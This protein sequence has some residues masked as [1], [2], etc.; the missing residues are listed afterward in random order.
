MR[1]SLIPRRFAFAISMV[2]G[3]VGLVFAWP[4]LVIYGFSTMVDP[5]LEHHNR[6]QAIMDRFLF[7]DGPWQILLITV[8]ILISAFGQLSCLVH[9]S[10]AVFRRPSAEF[11]LT[12]SGVGAVVITTVVVGCCLLVRA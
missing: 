8:L 5:R 6:T 3:V 2:S 7:G 1:G 10:C 12:I 11:S 9:L 4:L